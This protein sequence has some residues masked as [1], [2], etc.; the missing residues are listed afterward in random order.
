MP[1][2]GVLVPGFQPGRNLS[3]SGCPVSRHSR[4]GRGGLSRTKLGERD[5]S[6]MGVFWG[7]GGRQPDRGL[8]TLLLR[9]GD[10][11]SNPGPQHGQRC[12]RC[13]GTIKRNFVPLSCG[14]AACD[15]VC[16]RQE[17]CS[18]IARTQIER[19]QWFCSAECRSVVPAR[20]PSG[21]DATAS[22]QAPDTSPPTARV[23]QGLCPVCRN[24][25]RGGTN[26]LRCSSCATP[27]HYKCAN[28][29]RVDRA[30]WDEGSQW[31]CRHCQVPVAQPADGPVQTKSTSSKDLVLQDCL[32]VLQWNVDGLNTSF[33]DLEA[34]V[35]DR[36]IH[37]CLIQETKLRP[38][39]ATPQLPGY[40]AVRRD[41]GSATVP[42]LGN[43]GGLITYIRSDVPY[44]EVSAFRPGAQ[45][46]A[47]E[48]TA[49]RVRTR[50]DEWITLVNVYSPPST[51]RVG[52]FDLSI[53]S[54]SRNHLFAGDFNCHSSLWD[55]YQPEDEEGRKMEDWMLEAD[56]S[57]LNDGTPTRVNRATGG[58]SA[59]DL[60]V[61]H[62]SWVPASDWQVLDPLG[63]D[64]NPIVFELRLNWSSLSEAPAVLRWN[65]RGADWPAF[66]LRVEE[67]VA[68]LPIGSGARLTEMVASLTEVIVEAAR[69][70]VG[71]VRP[72]R[73]SG[74]SLTPD[75]RE[76]IRLRNS[77][78]RTIGENR[79]Q[80]RDACAR[81]RELVREA[82]TRRWREFVDSLSED[83]QSSRA[84]N[85][86]RSLSDRA[87]PPADRC[88]T[89]V[90]DGRAYITDSSKAAL[91]ARKYAA[92][93][94]HRFSREERSKISAVRR[95]LTVASRTFGP[96]GP[97]CSDFSLAELRVAVERMK[98]D[99]AEGPDKVAPRFIQHL[100]PAALEYFLGCCNRSWEEGFLPQQWRTATIIPILKGGKPASEV[101]SFRP[102]SLT[103][104]LGK[105]ME[106]LVCNRLYHIA[107]SQGLLTP[108]QAGF[109]V[110]RST[111]D[112]IL[113]ITQT[114][115]D[116][117]QAKPA[118][119]SVFALLDFSKAYDTVWHA[120]LLD[121]L[122]ASG[123]PP[124]YLCWIR[125]FLT[126][127]LGR[128]RV[129]GSLS[130]PRLFREGLPQ[131]SVLSPLLFLFVINS[132]RPR[133]R[134]S[135]TSI[136]A[137][138]VGMLA[139]HRHKE[140]AVAMIQADVEAVWAW[141]REHKL[142]LNVR[143]CEVTFFSS[144]PHE[145]GFQPQ[146]SVEGI[147]VRFNA[148]P[149]FLGIVYDRTLSFRPQVERVAG[150]VKSCNR[151]LGALSAR[152]WGW[153]PSSLKRVYQATGLS[154]VRYCGS[155][156]QPWLA[157]SNVDTLERAQNLC[158]RTIT[159][160]CRSAPVE[161][162]RLETGCPSIATVIK[163][164]TAIS[165]ELSLRLK[166]DN[167][168]RSVATLNVRHRTLRPGR[169]WRSFAQDL[170]RGVLGLDA[171][172]R[173]PLPPVSTAPWTF[174]VIDRNWSVSLSLLRGSRRSDPEEVRR[175]DAIDTVRAYPPF[176]YIVFTD[177]SAEGG[178]ACAG[179]AAV[180][181]RG[182]FE[183]PTYVSNLIQRGPPHTSSYEAE[184]AALSMAV[185]YLA[186]LDEDGRF[187]ICSDS[188][189][190]LA[191]MG[192]LSFGRSSGTASLWLRQ[193]AAQG[194]YTFQ[195]VP[196]HCGLLGNEMADAYAKQAARLVGRNP[197]P[198]SLS[199]AKAYIRRT[200]VDPPP[201]HARTREVYVA[202]PPVP[203]T[204]KEA[205]IL[206]QL[207]SGHSPVLQSYLHRIGVAQTPMC[208][209]CNEAEEDLKHFLQDCPATLGLRILEFGS[210][211]PP[212]SVLTE[213]CGT[214]AS[215][216]RQLRLL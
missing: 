125:G 79:E 179:S 105:V 129:N 187:L 10:I 142:S 155:G 134:S 90:C 144:D 115:S 196:G 194:S 77:L 172:P 106:R 206:A 17:K 93:S 201:E 158:L 124:R 135:L 148:T 24:R 22:T 54:S 13:S 2:R 164:D 61:V 56:F 199:S 48:A 19:E 210:G 92:V 184:L 174:P 50:R 85:V 12:A 147:D 143:K 200:L 32:R 122:Y 34:L 4:C 190:A 169:S 137:D 15:R 76:A 35:R 162:L 204:R 188:R 28:M 150:R 91:F 83:G 175:Q 102:I 89:M 132:L 44:T 140:V 33:V 195:W 107:E 183:L 86:I 170:G 66:Q 67:G 128:V 133:I 185:L 6:K 138:D 127:R 212:L 139:Q 159:G 57:C 14:S 25:T 101:E 18:D 45:C 103:S 171:Y 68:H 64:H 120:D 178:V 52:E 209:R 70:H 109:R 160:M 126:N 5:N 8:R 149:T 60:T 205:V 81:V 116:G 51:S 21:G 177:G 166:V 27:Y 176:D 88:R 131:G 58:L 215:Y 29:S 161:A 55:V 100:G 47:L 191:T 113:R 69:T 118:L 146:I 9:S 75:L 3:T 26:P 43:A 167:P 211:R 46:N 141:S 214:V 74:N 39:D 123:I 157:Q 65:W 78:G 11:E 193:Q 37:V 99:G 30:R 112:Q 198:V 145:A 63:S 156:W 94:R 203:S 53:L 7:Y 97:E 73:R 111:E 202:R 36:Q 168:R 41:R 163:R 82:K 121:I 42:T 114:I 98:P 72:A 95:R 80:W 49:I 173:A 197:A 40:V 136:F 165:M 189:A 181:C 182:D 180:I 208:P 119:R 154:M 152:N 207:R 213:D 216:L 1:Y 153:D 20:S 16:H 23:R 104:C 84:W 186:R 117:F 31:L 38:K 108:D 87:P 110:Q 96:L 151:M 130:S 59:P 71:M 62:H 192:S